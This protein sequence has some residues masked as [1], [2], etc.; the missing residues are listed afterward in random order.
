MKPFMLVL[1]FVTIIIAITIT[2]IIRK[3]K[4]IR[5]QKARAKETAML[6]LDDYNN[7]RIIK[8]ECGY[9][10]EDGSKNWIKKRRYYENYICP[11]C[12]R[13]WKTIDNGDWSW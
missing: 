10:A 12:G 3:I 4:R 9:I 1:L 5:W 8:C 7:Y 11:C 13:T 2:W 6:R